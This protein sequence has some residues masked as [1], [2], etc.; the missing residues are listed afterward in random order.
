MLGRLGRLGATGTSG[1]LLPEG[2]AYSNYLYWDPTGPITR[3]GPGLTASRDGGGAW[4]VGAPPCTLAPG[5]ACPTRCPS[6]FY[7]TVEC[8]SLLPTGTLKKRAHAHSN[9]HDPVVFWR[10]PWVK[11]L[12]T[13][14]HMAVHWRCRLPG[15]LCPLPR[16]PILLRLLSPG[17]LACHT[18]APGLPS[19]GLPATLSA[20]LRCKRLPRASA[21]SLLLCHTYYLN[22]LGC[23]G[24]VRLACCFVIRTT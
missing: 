8:R 2:D 22:C 1:T 18:D 3:A 13:W 6:V 15:R 7:G 20:T 19:P 11:D 14:R 17:L 21:I 4:A 5:Q 9:L 16:R 12:G 10:Y 23:P 24:L